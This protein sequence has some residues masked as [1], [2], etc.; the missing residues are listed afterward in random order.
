MNNT[1]KQG[2]IWGLLATVVMSIFMVTATLTGLSPMPAPIP[3]ALVKKVLGPMPKPVL[4]FLGI[5]AHLGYGGVAGGIL[6]QLFKE[7]INLGIG[8][9]WGVFLWL[10]MQVIFLPI[11]GWGLFG[12][13][14][15]PKVAVATLILHLIYG[16]T[17]G[18]G[19]QRKLQ[20]TPVMP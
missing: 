15:T 17:I 19:L 6:G 4:I 1:I 14:I 10:L 20:T 5:I 8:L 13:A 2:V 7:R 12:S 11:L 9:G 3:M 16:I 18:W